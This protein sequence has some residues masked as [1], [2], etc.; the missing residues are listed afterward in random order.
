MDPDR[1]RAAALH[2]LSEAE[3]ERQ[4]VP[5]AAS[6]RPN[7]RRSCSDAPAGWA[8]RRAGPGGRSHARGPWIYRRATAELEAELAERVR[9]LTVARPGA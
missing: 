2:L 3:R 5:A 7:R 6:A 8:D 1:A 9:E 4:H